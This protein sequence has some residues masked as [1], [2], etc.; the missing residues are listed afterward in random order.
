MYWRLQG[1]RP[2]SCDR[3]EMRL[4]SVRHLVQKLWAFQNKNV[5]RTGFVQAPGKK[6][7]PVRLSSPWR[8]GLR[9]Q[10]HYPGYND[11]YL[12]IHLVAAKSEYFILHFLWA[13]ELGLHCWFYFHI[14]YPCTWFFFG[15][16]VQRM[17]VTCCAQLDLISRCPKMSQDGRQLFYQMFQT[18]H[19]ALSRFWWSSRVSMKDNWQQLTLLLS[20]C[21]AEIVGKNAAGVWRETVSANFSLLSHGHCHVICL[22]TKFI[23]GE[24]AFSIGVREIVFLSSLYATDR[25]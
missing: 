15:L 22:F 12:M 21:C 18:Y 20:S 6:A 24:Y 14:L 25:L 9:C 13:S 10:Q 4:T 23:F 11:T 5:F 7:A 8:L 2:C 1:D 16:N 3:F 17:C 19:L